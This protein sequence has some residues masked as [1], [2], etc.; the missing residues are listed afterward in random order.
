[1]LSSTVEHLCKNIEDSYKKV[2]QHQRSE[3]YK[4]NEKKVEKSER[5]EKKI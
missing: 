3:S 1:L 5:S 4:K 2:C